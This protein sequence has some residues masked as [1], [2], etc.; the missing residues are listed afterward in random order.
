MII[1]I[2]RNGSDITSSVFIHDFSL[3]S[4]LDNHIARCK[5]TIGSDPDAGAPVSIWDEIA[6]YSSQEPASG[7]VP[8]E[9]IFGEAVFGG[10]IAAEKKIFGGY[11]TSIDPELIGSDGTTKYTAWH[12]TVHDYSLLLDVTIAEDK[13]YSGV[14]DDVAVKDLISTYLPEISTAGV[15][16]VASISISIKHRTLRRALES[17]AS[18]ASADWWIDAEKVLYY[19]GTAARPASFSLSE[20]PDYS[21]SFPMKQ[22]KVNYTEDFASPCN[23]CTVY[24]VLTDGGTAVSGTYQDTA[25]QT[26]YGRTFRRTIIDRKIQTA[27]ECALRAKA[28]V[29]RDAWPAGRGSVVFWRDGLEADQLLTIH[30]PSIHCDG[31]FRV[32][33]LSMVWLNSSTTEYSATF[34][35]YNP[36]LVTTLRKLVYLASDPGNTP[37]AVPSDHSTGDSKLDRTADPIQITDADVHDVSFSKVTDVIITDSQIH[38]V[39]FT[40]VTSV[41][42]NDSHIGTVHANSLVFSGGQSLNIDSGITYNGTGTFT[43]A[44]S[45]G[46]QITSVGGL[47]LTAGDISISSSHKI[48]MNGGTI[49]IDGGGISGTVDFNGSITVNIAVTTASLIANTPTGVAVSVHGG[50]AIMSDGQFVGPGGVDTSGDINTQGTYKQGGTSGITDTIPSSFSSITVKGGIITGW[51]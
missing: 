40:K 43:I 16:A 44:S 19:H 49:E 8:G 34:G 32:R 7:A 2:K 20:A 35:S 46:L 22:G 11:V 15:E 45:G 30:A 14:S 3:S 17:I 23:Y 5:L 47:S 36:D 38:D 4:D 6:I 51:S 13:T 26:Q 37:I 41:T 24:G 27:A 21:T 39:S 25:S 48:S 1:A 31:S 9:T 18:Q 28:E 29:L 12:V 42:I 10:P 50:S 33:K